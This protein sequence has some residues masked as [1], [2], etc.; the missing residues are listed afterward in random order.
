MTKMPQA[1]ID[2]VVPE[3]LDDDVADWNFPEIESETAPVLLG[4]ILEMM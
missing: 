4:D 3:W 1:E 2:E